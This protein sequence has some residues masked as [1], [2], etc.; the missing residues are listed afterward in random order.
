MTARGVGGCAWAYFSSCRMSSVFACHPGHGDG[1]LNQ[2][3]FL[4]SPGPSM[5]DTQRPHSC[6]CAASLP[7]SARCCQQR[8]PLAFFVG[9]RSEEHTSELQSLM[10]ISY[11]VLCLEQQTH[12]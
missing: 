2:N 6:G 7:T 3:H 5:L 1:R 12:T 9:M 4:S 11:A 8:T 10:R